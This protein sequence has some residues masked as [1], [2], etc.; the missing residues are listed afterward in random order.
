MKNLI[1]KILEKYSNEQINLASKASRTR[2]AQE[3]AARIA[4]VYHIAPY[5]NQREFE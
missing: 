4:N 5:A 2:L 1:V 3:I